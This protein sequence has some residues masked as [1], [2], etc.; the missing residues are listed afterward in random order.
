MFIKI[1][2]EWRWETRSVPCIAFLGRLQASTLN[3]TLS[4]NT[5]HQATFNLAFRGLLY[6]R[7]SSSGDTIHRPNKDTF[8]GGHCIDCCMVGDPQEGI[9]SI[10]LHPHWMGANWQTENV[11]FHWFD[12]KE[13]SSTNSLSP[14][15][16]YCSF[17]QVIVLILFLLNNNVLSCYILILQYRT[18]SKSRLPSCSF[19]FLQNSPLANTSPSWASF[20][21]CK[22]WGSEWLTSEFC[23]YLMAQGAQ[24]SALHPTCS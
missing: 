23:D 16:V 9:C 20:L 17:L 18:P 12:H 4:D 1:L 24:Q 13:H 5:G 10:K 11:I 3:R 6:R 15:L 19:F 2:F 14:R 7:P 8:W 21:I 22:M